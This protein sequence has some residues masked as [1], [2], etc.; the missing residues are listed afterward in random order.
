[1]FVS[2]FSLFL[3]LDDPLRTLACDLN[4]ESSALILRWKWAVSAK[5]LFLLL[6]LFVKSINFFVGEARS[7]QAALRADL[8]RYLPLSSSR[9]VRPIMRPSSSL[10]RLSTLSSPSSSTLPH[11]STLRFP[12]RP[13]QYRSVSGSTHQDYRASESKANKLKAKGRDEE[14][15]D[16]REKDETVPN[17]EFLSHKKNE[18]SIDGP[19]IAPSSVTSRRSLFPTNFLLNRPKGTLKTE[20][21][22]A[23]SDPSGLHYEDERF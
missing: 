1:M 17:E 4:I 10:I 21:S 19:S 3:L 8:L 2:L 6:Q 18:V 15:H 16:V 9:V 23:H 12:T 22:F 7:L 13:S 5:K 14:G 20:L 11:S